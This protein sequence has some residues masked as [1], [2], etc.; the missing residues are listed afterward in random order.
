MATRS[1]NE[2]RKEILDKIKGILVDSP[3]TTL[4]IQFF[5]GTQPAN[6]DL[7]P[8]A[9]KLATIIVAVASA[10]G[11]ATGG[12]AGAAG[13]LPKAGTWSGTVTTTGTVGWAR[14]LVNNV[15]D[16]DKFDVSCGAVASGADIEFDDVSFVLDG[17]VVID[18]FTITVPHSV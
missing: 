18:T 11:T 2:F 8:S 10:W 5:N 3:A 13:T 7:G 12:G 6:A 15:T 16:I 1:T 4:E 9:T 14:F 17:T